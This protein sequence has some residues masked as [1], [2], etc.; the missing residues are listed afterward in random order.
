MIELILIIVGW[1]LSGYVCLKLCSHFTET[2]FRELP[3]TM[4]ASGFLMG[5]FF[6]LIVFF[7]YW[8]FK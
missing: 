2:S 8:D 5:P 1:L 3:S 7:C 6:I 4:V